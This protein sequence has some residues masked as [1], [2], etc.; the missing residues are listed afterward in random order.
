M[1]NQWKNFDSLKLCHKET[2]NTENV[3]EN[4]ER[5]I[6]QIKRKKNLRFVYISVHV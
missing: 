6:H 5:F 1:I 3:N 2:Q 4:Q